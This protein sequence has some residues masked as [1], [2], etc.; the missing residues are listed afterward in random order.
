MPNYNYRCLKC[1]KV[2]ERFTTIAKRDENLICPCEK[3]AEVKRTVENTHINYSGKTSAIRKAG[4]GWND[5]LQRIKKAS[6]K[7]STI[8]HY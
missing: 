3:K 1:D 8:E 5:L 4:S 6:G 2:F 7:D